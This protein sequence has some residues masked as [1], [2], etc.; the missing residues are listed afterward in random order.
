MVST[1]AEVKKWGNS[2]GVVIPRETARKLNLS[3]GRKV[4]LDILPRRRISGF[5]I[6]KGAMPFKREAFERDL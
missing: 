2:L 6:A 1:V 5:G 4:Q 3:E